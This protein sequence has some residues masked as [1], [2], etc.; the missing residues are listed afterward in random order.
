M[1]V[2][3]VERG[4]SYCMEAIKRPKAPPRA[5]PMT[6]ETAVFPGQDSIRV[7]ICEFYIS[8]ANL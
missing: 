4:V 8:S 5:K 7:C 1:A 2:G 6:P 3:L